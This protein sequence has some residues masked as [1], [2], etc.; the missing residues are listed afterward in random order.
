MQ[1]SVWCWRTRLDL[2]NSCPIGC[3]KSVYKDHVAFNSFSSSVRSL[4]S[5]HWN[6]IPPLDRFRS[7]TFIRSD[8]SE[9]LRCFM[10]R[11][12]ST[13]ASTGSTPRSGFRRL[14]RTW[15]S[16]FSSRRWR[17]ATCYIQNG[18]LVLYQVDG[19]FQTSFC[20]TCVFLCCSNS[21]RPYVKVSCGRQPRSCWAS[22]SIG[23][24]NRVNLF[25]MWGAFRSIGSRTNY[26]SS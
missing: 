7:K 19:P 13:W 14:I 18:C 16:L 10:P 1:S 12:S 2:F 26:Q 5:I 6:G 17:S 15:H 22:S 21:W 9:L 23:S 3:I 4:F 24:P 8:S 20:F 11:C 25:W